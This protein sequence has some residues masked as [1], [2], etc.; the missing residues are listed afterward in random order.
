MSCWRVIVAAESCVGSGTCTAIAPD[1]FELDDDDRSRPVG[2]VGDD[3]VEVFQAA[4]MCPTG[5]IGVIRV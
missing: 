4:E 2:E 1:H 3:D 5:A